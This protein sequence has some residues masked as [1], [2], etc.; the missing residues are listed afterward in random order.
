MKIAARFAFGSVITA[1]LLAGAAP[2]FGYAHAVVHRAGAQKTGAKQAGAQKAG[3]LVP[4]LPV[5]PPPVAP[6]AFANT[7]APPELANSPSYI[8]IDD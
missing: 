3:K 8:L 2:G 7:P 1:A 4:A 6:L 5:G